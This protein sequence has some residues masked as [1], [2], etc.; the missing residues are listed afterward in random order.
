MDLSI[1]IPTRNRATTLPAMLHALARQTYPAD[2]YEVIVVANDCSDDTASVVRALTMPY[3]LS[4]IEIA[5]PGIARARNTGAA[6]ARAP[7]IAFLDDDIEAS[8]QFAAAHVEAHRDQ[9]DGLIVVGALTSPPNTGPSTLLVERLRAATDRHQS[10]MDA[11]IDWHLIT[12]GNMSVSAAFFSRV[13]GFDPAIVFYGAEDYDFAYRAAQEG[14]RFVRVAAASGIH[15]HLPDL[16]PA[17]YLRRARSSGRQDAVLAARYP[18]LSRYV[19]LGRADRGRTFVG[20]AARTLAFDFPRVGDALA[21]M[22]SGCARLLEAARAAA[23]WNRLMDGLYEY[24]YFRGVQSQIGS[25]AAVR[26]FLE[27]GRSRMES[28]RH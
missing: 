28:P 17:I 18:S 3:A 12:G 25:R 21:L 20:R 1:V 26:R 9:P 23:A 7:L 6:A 13:G 16:S 22:L 11:G 2:R 24:W 8:P 14:C 10:W 19:P 15:H 4:V 5:Q 27:E